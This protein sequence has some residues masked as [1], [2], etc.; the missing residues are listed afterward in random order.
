MDVTPH[1]PSMLTDRQAI[2]SQTPIA[3]GDLVRKSRVRKPYPAI[4][5]NSE[6]GM[7]ANKYGRMRRRNAYTS[8]FVFRVTLARSLT[9]ADPQAL[10]AG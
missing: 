4:T 6:T 10:H 8:T 9:Q 7:R 1:A 2:Q 3:N 5:K